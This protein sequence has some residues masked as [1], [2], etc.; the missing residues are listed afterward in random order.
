M[1]KS[2]NII[3]AVSTSHLSVLKTRRSAYQSVVLFSYIHIHMR[4]YVRVYI[5]RVYLLTKLVTNS[6]VVLPC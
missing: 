2:F 1:A 3:V 4:V 5:C 6:P